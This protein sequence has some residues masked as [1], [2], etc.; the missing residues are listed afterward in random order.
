MIHQR[1]RQ[2]D[3]QMTCDLKTALCTIVHRAVKIVL[4]VY[5]R[6]L[7]LNLDRITNQCNQQQQLQKTDAQG[8]E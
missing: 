5:G 1:H 7:T 3:G 2:I 8:R 4:L 6:V